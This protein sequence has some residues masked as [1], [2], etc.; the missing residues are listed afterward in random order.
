MHYRSLTKRSVAF[1][2]ELAS[3]SP[4]LLE[5]DGTDFIP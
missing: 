2:N 1:A 3:L 5:M 4:S